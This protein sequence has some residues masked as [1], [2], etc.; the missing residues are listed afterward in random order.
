MSSNP[1]LADVT[2]GIPELKQNNKNGKLNVHTFPTNHKLIQDHKM[3]WQ[4]QTF[5]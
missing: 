3:I 4:G 2:G 1:D 5:V